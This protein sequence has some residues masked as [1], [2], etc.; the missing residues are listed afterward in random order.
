MD[1]RVFRDL[2]SWILVLSI[3]AIESRKSSVFSN[4]SVKGRAARK[5]NDA[6]KEASSPSSL[7]FDCEKL[8]QEKIEVHRQYVMVNSR[9]DER[10][11]A[12][13]WFL[14]C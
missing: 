3:I 13:H 1:I 6:W 9:D 10:E 8:A 7:K 11:K 5:T 14:P 4:N 2:L 12:L